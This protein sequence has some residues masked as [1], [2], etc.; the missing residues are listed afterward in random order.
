M[1][2][3]DVQTG[4]VIFV[5]KFPKPLCLFHWCD[6]KTKGRRRA[7]DV[8][9]ASVVDM[10]MNTLSFD[11]TRQQWMLEP[12]PIIMPTAGMVREYCCS[13]LSVDGDELLTGSTVGDLIVFK[14]SS[15]VYR[16]SVP[17]C[18]GG[19]RAMAVSP[20]TF[21]VFCGG[22][23][24]TV[25]RLH[26]DDMRWVLEAET[27]LIGAVTSMSFVAGAGELLVGT[28]AGRVYRI[29]VDDLSATL[30]ASSHTDRVTC[31]AFG[32]RSD[33]F[34]SA[35]GS[36]DIKV[37]DLSDYSVLGETSVALTDNLRGG[38][39]CI[40]WVY[41]SAIVSGWPDGFVRC[42]NA[43][44]MQR[45][46]EIPNAHRSAVTALATHAD[47]SLAY[48][49]SG[50]ADGSVRVWTLRSRELMLQFTEHKK[51]VTQVLVDVT[52]P[53]LIHSA[54]LDCQVLT[55]DLRRQRRV[56]AHMVRHWPAPSHT[57]A[58][59]TALLKEVAEKTQHSSE[60]KRRSA[61]HSGGQ[62]PVPAL[63][64][65]SPAQGLVFFPFLTVAALAIVIMQMLKECSSSL[66]LSI[67]NVL[68]SPL[69]F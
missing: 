26:G 57:P 12:Q 25:K 35:A 19:L 46:W 41:D 43:A 65:R 63:G 18:S 2:I 42:H 33:V 29:S 13:A 8:A 10:T 38:A 47:A 14:L 7:Y 48:L 3:W 39:L 16:A 54:G 51:A 66:H 62:R 58:S 4:E 53:N 22:G 20:K 64:P 55:Y 27:R 40:A 17:T 69:C 60:I 15:R 50:G 30:V 21:Q 61:R 59:R 52:S 45:L 32:S 36:G 44:T 68:A 5:R 9:V 37:W 11:P 56:V 67:G 28:D 49:V 6:T 23:D 1:H 31:L 34:A 24:G